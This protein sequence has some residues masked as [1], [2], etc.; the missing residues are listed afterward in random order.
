[1]GPGQGA[2]RPRDYLVEH[3][4]EPEATLVID[5]TGDL[6]K[7]THTVGV[8][9]QYTGTAAGRSAC[10]RVGF[11]T[12]LALAT[13]MICRAL[14]AGVPAAW[15]AGD[16]VYGANPTLR[17][18]L[19]ARVRVAGRRWTVEEA[20]RPARACVVWIS[21]RSAAGAPGTAGPRSPTTGCAG[22][23]GD[24]DIKP[25]PEPATP[26]TGSLGPM[27]ITNYGWSTRSC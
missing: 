7:G 27:N 8:Q 15:V 14:D 22:R 17:A 23:C 4:G 16:E 10:P 13:K 5:E 26:P 18:E 11:A 9:R 24:A 25:A 20:F 3:L 2:R 21:I 6:K 19:E 12:K 1:V